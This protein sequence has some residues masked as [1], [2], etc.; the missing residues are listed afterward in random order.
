[1]KV[2][3]CP[4][5]IEDFEINKKCITLNCSHTFHSICIRNWLKKKNICPYCRTPADL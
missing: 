1:M 2:D 3:E 5:C 4:I